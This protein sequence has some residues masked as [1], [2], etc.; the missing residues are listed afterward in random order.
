M[1]AG[2]VIV[3]DGVVEDRVAV[4]QADRHAV[5]PVRFDAVEEE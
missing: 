1:H 3:R 2:E 5:V 4:R